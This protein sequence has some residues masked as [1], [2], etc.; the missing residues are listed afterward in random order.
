MSFPKLSVVFSFRNEEQVIPELLRRCR[1]VCA[2]LKTEKRIASHEFVFVDDD[3]TDKSYPML[4]KEADEIG[5]VKVIRMSRRFGVS[6]C[7]LAGIRYA[8]GDWV[9]YMDT[10]LQDPP[11]LIPAMIQVVEKD[12]EVA[13]VHTRRLR[14]D[15]EGAFKLFV[16]RIGY[17]ILHLLT[18]SQLPIECGDFKL[19]TRRAVE[20]VLKFQETKPF[21]RW[22]VCLVGFKQAFV[23]YRREARGAGD[24]HFNVL[25]WRVISNFM[26]SALVSTSVFPLHIISAFGIFSSSICGFTLVY[27]LF[28]K[29]LGYNLP[30]W[31]AIMAAILF[32][33]SIQ[34][35]SIGLLGLYIGSIFE[36]VKGRPNYIVSE[37]YGF[38]DATKADV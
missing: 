8:S 10:D 16:T 33:G 13:V 4:K 26:E 30:G 25:S 21:M 9:V 31:T 28:E 18:R 24:T 36:Q 37:T 29:L 2:N 17:I 38:P 11:E 15:G 6:V 14:R 19:L 7:V 23:P 3:S 32:V 12:P 27:I 20:E 22:L 35:L 1:L 5:D 34:I